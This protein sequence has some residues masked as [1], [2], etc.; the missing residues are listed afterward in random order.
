MQKL[1]NQG[2]AFEFLMF[3]ISIAV[4]LPAERAGN[5]MRN[6][7][8]FQYVLC[9][10]IDMFEF[11]DSLGECPDANKMVYVVDIAIRIANHLL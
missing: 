8:D 5:I 11:A 10:G 1:Q 6:G 3:A 9:L 7:G 4:F 2:P